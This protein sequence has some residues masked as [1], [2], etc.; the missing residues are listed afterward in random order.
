MKEENV[1]A[2]Q[3]TRDTGLTN[4]LITQWKKKLQKPSI[5]SIIK[6]AEYFDVSVDYITGKTDI[7]K[8]PS[9]ESEELSKLIQN[10]SNDVQKAIRLLNGL[11]EE[12]YNQAMAYL[13]FLLDARD[14]K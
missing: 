10:S 4:G 1:T 13:H 11:D 2:A 6:L 14:K 12:K 9:H 5:E 3:L 7:K 8:S